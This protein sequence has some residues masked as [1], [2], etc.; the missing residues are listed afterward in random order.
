MQI[1]LL[2][3]LELA[4]I[5]TESLEF[6]QSVYD[7]VL[8]LR[9]NPDDESGVANVS[10]GTESM[11]TGR[12]YVRIGEDQEYALMLQF[13]KG[14]ANV[15]VHSLSHF[16]G[17][18]YGDGTFKSG[19]Y[20]DPKALV[21]PAI[22]GVNFDLFT[23]STIYRSGTAGVWGVI[24]TANSGKSLLG[25]V[26]A[27]QYLEANPNANIGVI[28]A[29][30]P[31]SA[32]AGSLADILIQ[33]AYWR[34]VGSKFVVLDSMRFAINS[35]GGQLKTQGI[36]RRLAGHMTQMNRIAAYAG[37]TVYSVFNPSSSK[38]EVIQEI[39]EDMYSSLAVDMR[40]KSTI[41]NERN[42]RV[43][44]RIDL[45]YSIRSGDRSRET[46]HINFWAARDEVDLVKLSFGSMDL[47]TAAR[48]LHQL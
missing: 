21:Q 40:L 31:E 4:H 29:G 28:S 10:L 46:T 14:D 48:T 43:E 35:M 24:S 11:E 8:D 7:A 42:D 30:E 32:D 9:D 45:D 1:K 39:G 6:K 47:N 5:A 13:T 23:D 15:R 36:S 19:T 33:L 20:N 22:T 38:P 26:L 27:S 41:V 18:L 12:F 3:Q 44:F 34:V 37:M 2:P 17:S 16:K 25:T